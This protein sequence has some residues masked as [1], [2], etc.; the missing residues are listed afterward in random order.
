[1]PLRINSA[2]IS[3]VTRL[4]TSSVFLFV[5]FTLVL[6]SHSVS[7]QQQLSWYKFSK[8]FIT[9]KY[10]PD[11]AIGSLS[12]SDPRPAKTA[13]VPPTCGA[14]DGEIHIGIAPEAITWS[15]AQGTS[16]SSNA[17]GTEKFGIVAEPVNMSKSTMTIVQGSK[18]A[19]TTFSGYFRFWNEGHDRGNAAASNPH[20]VLEMHPVWAFETEGEEPFDDPASIRPMT[21]Y[22]GYGASHFKPL[23]VSLTAKRWLLVYEDDDYIYVQMVKADNFYQLPVK[24]VGQAQ[25]VTGGVVAEANV[26]SDEAHKN[27][28]YS[29][30]RRLA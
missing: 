1:M 8:D 5:A 14:K 29:A 9:Q 13:H 19:S 3:T 7:A 28:I 10:P 20:H 17:A 30:E 23:L 4:S 24:I 15:D 6:V 16:A 12:S 25:S 11:S 27:N 18:G 2:I 26:F 21:G 22:A